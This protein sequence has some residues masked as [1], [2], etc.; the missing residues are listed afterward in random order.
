MATTSQVTVPPGFAFLRTAAEGAEFRFDV[1]PIPPGFF[2]PRSHE[3][4]RPIRFRGS[5]LPAV[6]FGGRRITHVDTVV[7]RFEPGRFSGPYP[8]TATVPIEIV[9]L[10]LQSCS[11]LDVAVGSWTEQ[12]VARVTLSS[13]RA[14]RGRM[15]I[16]R[17]NRVGGVFD[18]ELNVIPVF[19]FER[20]CDGKRAVLDVGNLMDMPGIAAALVMTSTET[21]W[22]HRAHGVLHLPG[23]NDGFVAGAPG[24]FDERGA[25]CIHFAEEA[26]GCSVS[27]SAESRCLTIGRLRTFTA[28]ASPPGGT[29][30][31][32]IAAGASR[33]SIVQ[34]ATSSVATVRGEGVSGSAEDITLNVEY[35][36]SGAAAGCS[37]SVLL[38]TVRVAFP[39]GGFRTSG[40]FST[41]NSTFPQ[42]AHGGKRLGPIDPGN[43]AN[44]IGWFNKVEI[45]G[46]VEPNA[47]QLGCKLAFR[48]ERQGRSGT[49]VTSPP[50]SDFIPDGKDCPAPMWCPDDPKPMFG[51]DPTPA[52]DGSIFMVDAPGMHTEGAGGN[53]TCSNS[54]FTFPLLCMN[55]RVWVEVDG[56]QCSDTLFWHSSTRIRCDGSNFVRDASNPTYNAFGLGSILECVMS[57]AIPLPFD[58]QATL[59]HLGSAEPADWLRGEYEARAALE[60]EL[61]SDAD[62]GELIEA[63]LRLIQTGVESDGRSQAAIAFEL[64]GVFRP[65]DAPAILADHVL[66]P[67]PN[68][69]TTPDV[70]LPTVA[71]AL[72]RQG[73]NGVF[74]ILSRV[75]TADDAAWAMLEATL[76]DIA[77]QVDVR[78]AICA[79]LDQVVTDH[80]EQRLVR[81]H[82]S[83]LI[84]R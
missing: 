29:Y 49:L 21:P 20:V 15:T 18:S 40:E 82:E 16:T 74:E 14:P 51:Q 28:N 78:P 8:Q 22:L 3:Y 50:G 65:P 56:Q 12:W 59:D 62:R 64:L 37:A 71:A 75:G 52:S 6:Y 30:K 38:T 45:R 67:L 42:Q 55:F 9:G 84:S 17:L 66:D 77:R 73:L 23:L 46:V 1:L 19:E 53:T 54:P 7:R 83:P 36:P 57:S 25:T 58:L 4:T 34:G 70:Y 27:I 24:S 5:S 81:L 31:W 79:A 48:Q 32:M 69:V 33:A 43:P 11:P 39:A 80:A 60:S 35:T 63:L 41:E 72:A 76:L 68:I 44:A 13:A 2:H 26:P 10:S 61:V 47:G